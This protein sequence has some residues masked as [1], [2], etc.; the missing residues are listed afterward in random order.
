MTD[1]KQNVEITPAMIGAGEEVIYG[2]LGAGL[3]AFLSGADLAVRVY[4]AMWMES[5]Q[6]SIEQL[7]KR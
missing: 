5:G 6:D 7:L 4:E 3:P 2:E 1:D